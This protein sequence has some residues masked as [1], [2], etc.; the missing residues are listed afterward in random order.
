VVTAFAIVFLF[1]Q[2]PRALRALADH[3]RLHDRA[4]R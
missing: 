2:V 1:R 3:A 4:S